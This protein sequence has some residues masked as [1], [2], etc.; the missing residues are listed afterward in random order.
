MIRNFE[1]I[2]T[3]LAELATVINSFKSE[4]VQLRIVDLLFKGAAPP[5]EEH[6]AFKPAQRR[7]Q[8]GER[9]DSGSSS[10]SQAAGGKGQR[11]LKRAG[12]GGMATLGILI[13]EGFFSKRHALKGITDHIEKE[14]ARKFRQSDLSG[15]LGR[16]V[17]DGT[18]K[19]Q[20]NAD[21]QYEY[22]KP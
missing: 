12:T 8:R 10:V 5:E 20:K 14:K 7:R 19:R 13:D 18:L 21:G 1:Q 15:P 11:S 22:W 16:L 3:Q 2:K 4:A 9:D 6:E 17:R